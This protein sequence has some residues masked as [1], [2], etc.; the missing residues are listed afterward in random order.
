MGLNRD[1]SRAGPSEHA[2]ASSRSGFAATTFLGSAGEDDRSG[3]PRRWSGRRHLHVAA[4]GPTDPQSRSREPRSDCLSDPPHPGVRYGLGIA[5]HDVGGRR[6]PD[7]IVDTVGSIDGDPSAAARDRLLELF[8]HSGNISG[9]D[10]AQ[11]DA[12]DVNLVVT[13]LAVHACMS[14]RFVC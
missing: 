12:A 2:V 6:D 3:S 5:D 7:D 14:R 10:I 13:L 4:D 9:V 8:V 1:T 11:M